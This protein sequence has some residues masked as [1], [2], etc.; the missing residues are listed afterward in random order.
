MK[1]AGAKGR[2]DDVVSNFVA[3]HGAT[4][5]PRPDAFRVVIVGRGK[6]GSALAS[7]L[8]SRGYSATLLRS[9][10]RR[11]IEK[12]NL[13]VFAVPDP[14][15]PDVAARF[16]DLLP[17]KV[18]VAHCAGARSFT[19]LAAL[20]DRGH[21]ACQMHPLLSFAGQPVAFAGAAL[22][23]DGDP[24]SVSAAIDLA[25]A[26]DMRAFSLAGVDLVQYHA[27]AALLAN[28]GVAL[29]RAFQELTTSAGLGPT[30]ASPLASS[31]LRSVSENLETVGLPGALTGP[32]RRGDADAV[33]AHLAR[34]RSLQRVAAA[35]R[36]LLPFQV[37]L[38][39]EIGEATPAARRRI[40]SLS[41]ATSKALKAPKNPA[42]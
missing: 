14:K 23:V 38:S 24:E 17:A 40:L 2:R 6:V 16:V 20:R 15:I 21:P 37:A 13:V 9:T 1:R 31:L 36:V 10:H 35:Y 30:L 42:K 18:P 5:P 41:R 22:G 26:L 12:A 29:A 32:V 33:A 39:A 25:R 34:L 28:G 19:L 27:A 4:R 7:A 8:G 3:N 11:S